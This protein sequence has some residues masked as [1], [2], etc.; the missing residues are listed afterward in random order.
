MLHNYNISIHFENNPLL[1]KIVS[2]VNNNC[3]LTTLWEI[4]NVNAI[5][6][7]G[8]SDNGF[9]HCQVVANIA[10]RISRMLVGH[11]IEMSVTKNYDLSSK[12]AEVII[13]LA[14]VMHDIGM[15]IN[16]EAHEEYSLFLARDLLKE[17]LDFLPTKEKTIVI[18]ETLHAILNHK[19]YSR[20]VTLEAGIV[21]VADA[22][23]MT[24]GRSRIPFEA[25]KVNMHLISAS[26]IETIDIREG[27][28]RPIQVDI[29]MNNSSGLF[30]VDELLKKKLENSN[31][32][33]YI[34]VRA[35]IN[36]KRENNL[37]REFYI[38]N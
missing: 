22:L 29:L 38:G 19:S 3:E 36:Q 24:K 11:D 23:D 16:R 30:Q 10:L 20:P 35:Y 5:E 37:I 18:S 9:T 27:S 4:S 15:S 2:L 34:E 31:I 25:G 32:K 13:F 7:L 1:E 14:S 21:R 8:Y 12:Y 17:M 6:R 33:Q 26:A 28:Y